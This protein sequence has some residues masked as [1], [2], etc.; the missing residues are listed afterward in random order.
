MAFATIAA[1]NSQ[2][3]SYPFLVRIY[4]RNEKSKEDH[5]GGVI[6]GNDLILTSAQCCT[7]MGDAII[8]YGNSNHTDYVNG[9]NLDSYSE[10]QVKRKILHDGFEV[11]ADGTNVH[12]LCLMQ[13]V[14]VL[15]SGDGHR[16]VS[17]PFEKPDGAKRCEL[18]GWGNLLNAT[19]Q[20]VLE[21]EAVEPK[22]C[23]DGKALCVSLRANCLGD[24]GN[25]IVCTDSTG[26]KFVYGIDSYYIYTEGSEM[27]CEDIESNY[28]VNLYKERDFLK[29]YI[30]SPDEESGE[31]ENGEV[32]SNKSEKKT[33]ED[34]KEMN[35]SSP[36]QEGA[37][38]GTDT[39]VSEKQSATG[40][41]KDRALS[42]G[43]RTARSKGASGIGFGIRQ[44]P[45][46]EAGEKEAAKKGTTKRTTEAKELPYG[47]ARKHNE[48]VEADVSAESLS[49]RDTEQ[50]NRETETTVKH[51]AIRASPKQAQTVSPAGSVSGA[52]AGTTAAAGGEGGGGPIAG[53]GGLP[54]WKLKANLNDRLYDDSAEINFYADDRSV[55]TVTP[56][57]VAVLLAILFLLLT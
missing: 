14:R 42:T 9:R 15:P 1:V 30:K 3:L 24:G 46:E 2:G 51:D 48:D 28:F 53:P 41:Q 29:R 27:T 38:S 56:S 39:S 18:A 43:G 13:T 49:A 17:L 44:G 25:P 34:N 5:C 10:A 47:A 54:S 19:M 40:Y 35:R 50:S 37:S 45:E 36:D 12:D 31:T 52:P 22:E 7:V 8:V 6:V 33:D 20:H 26:K 11:L 32:K 4:Y 23:R 57:S 55:T 21:V 16:S